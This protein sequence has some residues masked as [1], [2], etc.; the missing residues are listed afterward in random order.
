M[1]CDGSE[2]ISFAKRVSSSFKMED[3]GS[4]FLIFALRILFARTDLWRHLARVS[5]YW[6]MADLSWYWAPLLLP[7]RNLITHILASPGQWVTVF[8][9]GNDFRI[10]VGVIG[11]I[12][13][14]WYIKI[15]PN[16]K[17]LGTRL[18]W[19]NPT[20]SAFIPQR[21]VLSSIVLAWILIYRNWSIAEYPAYHL[22]LTE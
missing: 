21:L 6:N 22:H 9:V 2:K 11:L 4:L 17:D 7:R 3:V 20:N 18:L 10:F 13:Q 1:D 12:D 19:I 16:T 8:A 14:F 5:A 15:Q